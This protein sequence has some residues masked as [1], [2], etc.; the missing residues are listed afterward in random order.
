MIVTNT[1]PPGHHEVALWFDVV[2]ALPKREHRT[3][4]QTSTWTGVQGRSIHFVTYKYP[5]RG[6]KAKSAK[7]KLLKDMLKDLKSTFSEYH[8]TKKL[9]LKVVKKMLDAANQN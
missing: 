9:N 1:R 4:T 7:K 8:A 6:S 3:F 5:I 2:Q